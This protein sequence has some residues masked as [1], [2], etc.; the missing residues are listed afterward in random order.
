MA[1]AAARVDVH[2]HLWSESLVAALSRR[3]AAPRVRGTGDRRELVL[4]TEP[5]WPL[6]IDDPSRRL[7]L[8]RRDGVDRALVALSAAIGV[9]ELAPDAADPLIAAYAADV[10]GL[11]DDFAAWGSLPLADPAPCRV[12]ALLDEGFAGLCLPATALASGAALDRLGPALERL[13]RRGAPLF[14]HPSPARERMP[15]GPGW[16]PAAADYLPGLQRAWLAFTAFGRPR[17]PRLR[18]L[19]AALAG[20][21][22]LHAERIAAR[23][24]PTRSARDELIF[25]DTSSYGPVAIA[26]MDTAVGR[27]QLAYG[28]DRPVAEPSSEP[29]DDLARLAPARLFA[30]PTS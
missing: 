9:E 21:A 25:Y 12:D 16:W 3:R 30:W 29:D 10:R 11:P 15:G 13:E 4:A 23:G 6:A 7:S 17:H 18:V 27:S 19:F 24:G 5:A 1:P 22:P 14:V 2:Q 20:L 8:L 26:A 28:S